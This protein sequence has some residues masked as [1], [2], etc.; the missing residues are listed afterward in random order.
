MTRE[1]RERAY[2]EAAQR[3]SHA[4]YRLALSVLRNPYDAEDAVS[5]AFENAWAHLDR[6][7]DL[8]AMPAFLMRC[9]LN[10]AR[11]RKRKLKKEAPAEIREEKLGAAEEGDPVWIYLTGLPEK[12]SVP[13]MLH[14]GDDF[15]VEE[16]AEIL[17]IPRG[18]VSSRISRGLKMLRD[19]ME[20]GGGKA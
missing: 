4:M 16:I 12:F 10:S 6:I 19:E 2:T 8:D 9:A 13:M 5:E 20:E 1:E 14:F 17:R 11:D 7:R 15:T 18:T 3:R